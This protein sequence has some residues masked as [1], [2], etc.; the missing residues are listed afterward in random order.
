M[1]L[2]TNLLLLLTFVITIDVARSENVT[3]DLAILIVDI[4]KNFI[5]KPCN[6]VDCICTAEYKPVCG[7]D[8]Q[9]YGNECWFKCARKCNLKL[10]IV[11]N[12][13][14]CDPS[15]CI[16]PTIVQPVCGSDGITYENECRFQCVEECRGI[17]IIGA[18][19][20]K[21]GCNI[22]TCDCPPIDDPVCG[23]DGV[24]YGNSCE[25]GSVATCVENLV[26]SYK[27]ECQQG[28]TETTRA[29]CNPG[30]CDCTDVIAEPI[31]A[32]DGASYKTFPNECEFKC[33]AS[34]NDKLL[35]AYEG[36]CIPI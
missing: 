2:V 22:A 35:I 31:C 11:S 36:E 1:K 19:S 16:C 34:C 17:R 23:S 12:G 18:G 28:V 13:T 4:M 30:A 20:C 15:Y 14:C 21:Q 8:R 10:K 26:Q 6:P 25:L 24:T 32:A 33:S 7:S 5:S 9:T 27:G 29:P 3:K